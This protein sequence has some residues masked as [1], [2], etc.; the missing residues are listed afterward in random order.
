MLTCR[1][2]KGSCTFLG[3]GSNVHAIP[4][5]TVLPSVGIGSWCAHTRFRLVIGV[6]L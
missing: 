1:R 3:P 5:P 6:L 2:E 4:N